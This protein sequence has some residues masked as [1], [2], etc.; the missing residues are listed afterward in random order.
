MQ[1]RRDSWRNE[2]T[3]FGAFVAVA[4]LGLFTLGLVAVFGSGASDG[5]AGAEL[6]TAPTVAQYR[7]GARQSMS[8][9]LGAAGQLTL[10]DIPGVREDLL[11]IVQ[12]TQDRLIAMRV[13]SDE[14]DAH[15]AL[16]L[17]MEQWKRGLDADD[18]GKLTAVFL[19]TQ[20]FI[21]AHPWI[22]P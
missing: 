5:L 9:F 2:F 10:E 3:V 22:V 21:A 1:K 14:R 18:E 6:V 20:D 7:D 4:F 13:P 16:V 12:T 15:L 11:T 19:Q 8:A 17:L